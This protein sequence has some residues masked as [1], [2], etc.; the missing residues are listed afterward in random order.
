MIQEY[1]FLNEDKHLKDI[2]ENYKEKVKIEIENFG[3]DEAFIVKYYTD[4]NNEDDAKLLSE[5][6]E[7]IRSEFHTTT[8]TNEAAAYFNKRLYPLFN[9][10]ERKLRKV[11]YL[12][13]TYNDVKEAESVVNNIEK[14]TFEQM[15]KILFTDERLKKNVT[16]R[17]NNG[18]N[19]SKKDLIAIIQDIPESTTWHVIFGDA[20]ECVP[21]DFLRIKEY[22]ND[23]MHAHNINYKEFISAKNLLNKVN[24]AIDKEI[25]LYLDADSKSLPTIDLSAVIESLNKA[26]EA[27]SMPAIENIYYS[28]SEILKRLKENLIILG[29]DKPTY[30]YIIPQNDTSKKDEKDDEDENEK[31]EITDAKG[32]QEDENNS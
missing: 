31:E 10:F 1:L 25:G 15:Y 4:T 9:E 12:A 28:A 30:D 5:L 18:N 2:N 22:R 29:L 13:S 16:S 21:D 7:V 19:Y 24:Q 11:I 20:L 6:D 26:M 3:K 27:I 32:K 17:F 14:Y 23:T 8:L